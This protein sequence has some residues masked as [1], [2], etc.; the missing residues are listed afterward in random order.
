VICD[1]C[2]YYY[3]TDVCDECPDCGASMEDSHVPSDDE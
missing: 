2:D 1:H 3:D